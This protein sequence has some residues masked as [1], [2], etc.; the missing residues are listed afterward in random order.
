MRKVIAFVF[1]I[2][3]TFV[4]AGAIFVMMYLFAVQP[5]MVKGAS[6]EYNFYDGD[7]ILTEKISYRFRE[8]QRGEVIVFKAPNRPDVDYIK[9]VIA[10][11]N[12]TVKLKDGKIYINDVLLDE[13]YQPDSE[14]AAG[15][16]LTEGQSFTVPEGS[17]FVLGDNRLHSSDSREF[18]TVAFEDIHGRAVWRYWPAARFGSISTPNYAIASE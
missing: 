2:L 3:Q 12:E 11:P 16:F 15:K 13:A 17:F 5:N 9:R 6:M 1:D 4:L 18:G 14:T 8:P 7:Y 10:L